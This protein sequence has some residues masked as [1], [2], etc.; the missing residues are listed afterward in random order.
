LFENVA[1]KQFKTPTDYF[2]IG[3]GFVFVTI[4]SNGSGIVLVKTKGD[5]E[6]AIMV[7]V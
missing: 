3:G 2:H 7:S 6:Q 5:F 1:K 4:N